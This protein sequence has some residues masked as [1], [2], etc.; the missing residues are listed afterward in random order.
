MKIVAKRVFGNHVNR[1]VAGIL[2]F[3]GMYCSAVSRYL[4]LHDTPFFHNFVEYPVF[5]AGIVD[6]KD[7]NPVITS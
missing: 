3:P 6:G 4:T 5:L 1:M 2:Y 7:F